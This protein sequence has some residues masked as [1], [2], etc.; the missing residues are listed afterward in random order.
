MKR[1]NETGATIDYDQTVRIDW[2]LSHPENHLKCDE[3]D[4]FIAWKYFNN[5]TARRW[6]LTPDAEGT[7]ETYRTLCPKCFDKLGYK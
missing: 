5:G 3:C 6:L 4:K 2:L 7:T 1:D